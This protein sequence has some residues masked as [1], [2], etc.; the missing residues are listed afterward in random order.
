MTA[1]VGKKAQEAEALSQGNFDVDIEVFGEKDSLGNSFRKMAENIAGLVTQTRSVSS[2]LGSGI[3]QVAATADSLSQGTTEQASSLEQISASVNEIANQVRENAGAA[4]KA[5]ETASIQKTSADK[6]RAQIEET[7]KAMQEI[8]TSSMQISK[9]IKTIDD[10]AFQTNLLALNAAVEAARA[11]RHGKGFAVVADEVRSLAGRSAKAAA[12]TSQLI[13]TSASR[14]ERGLAEAQQTEKSFQDIL[15]GAAEVAFL[16]SEIATQSNAQAQ[17]IAQISQG[18]AQVDQVVQHTT[19]SAEQTASAAKELSALSSELDV[20]LGKFKTKAVVGGSNI[21]AS[22]AKMQLRAEPRV[23]HKAEP[24]VEH[25]VDVKAEPKKESHVSAP[26]PAK[27]PQP[28]PAPV[29]KPVTHKP[30]SAVHAA[31]KP[32][33]TTNAAHGWGG[34]AQDQPI[35]TPDPA[36][37]IAL[38]DTE[39]GKYG[40]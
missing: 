34:V 29:V 13:E 2:K 38:T 3:G 35:H 15:D 22:S 19:A 30:A 12:E 32:A 39:F 20:V 1:R 37:I 4:V 23:E 26:A 24:K 33:Q 9:I 21:R 16:V 27:A 14:V 10:I 6:G 25:K 18:L 5:N 40:K 8:N 7:V 36:E 17:S 28:K 31:P 11:G